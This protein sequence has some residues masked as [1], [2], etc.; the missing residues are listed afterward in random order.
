MKKVS[1]AKGS[2]K[3]KIYDTNPSPSIHQPFHLQISIPPRKPTN[4]QKPTPKPQAIQL[5]P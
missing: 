3:K 1:L 5:Q 4:P 2:P